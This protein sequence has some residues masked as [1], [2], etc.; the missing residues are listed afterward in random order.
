ML[1]EIQQHYGR[2][3]CHK[4][5]EVTRYKSGEVTL[6]VKPD[7]CCEDKDGNMKWN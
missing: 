2:I 6:V 7:M 3:I 5:S 1:C 4:T